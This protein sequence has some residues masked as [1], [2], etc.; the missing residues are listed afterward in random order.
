SL[1]VGLVFVQID[2]TVLVGI[3]LVPLDTEGFGHLIEI[4]QAVAI[5]I[6][7]LEASLGPASRV[8]SSS[9]PVAPRAATPWSPAPR[10]TAAGAPFAHPSLHGRHKLLPGDLAVGDAHVLGHPVEPHSVHFVAGHD[11]LAA[12]HAVEHLV[13]IEAPKALPAAPTAGGAA[14]PAA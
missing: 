2:K 3:P 10:T 12:G 13:G 9:A 5:L 4:Q 14:L 1:D 11:V 6:E 8:A 7:P